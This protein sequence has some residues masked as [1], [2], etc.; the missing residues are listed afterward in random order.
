MLAKV[1][2][3]MEIV[4]VG[5][6]PEDRFLSGSK[7]SEINGQGM[8]TLDHKGLHFNGTLFDEPYT[9]DLTTDQVPTY[10]MCT[11][12]SRFYTFVDGKFIEFFPE[13]KT[14]LRWVHATE[15]MHRAEGGKWKE[16][17]YRHTPDEF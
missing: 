4:K 9:F 1:G 6:L 5:T 8:L 7:T 10:G 15:E 16:V 12:I 17:E 2:V 13:D 14:V 3:R 11:D